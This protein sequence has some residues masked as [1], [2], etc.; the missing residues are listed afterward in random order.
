MRSLLEDAFND[1]FTSNFGREVELRFCGVVTSYGCT[2]ICDF[3]INIIFSP[4][5]IFLKWKC[6]RHQSCT[7]LTYTLIKFTPRLNR[8]MNQFSSLLWGFEAK[9]G[10]KNFVVRGDQTLDLALHIAVQATLQSCILPAWSAP[11]WSRCFVGSPWGSHHSLWLG[12][13]P[14]L[15]RVFPSKQHR[16]HC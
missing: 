14:I 2:N 13:K 16:P 3:F 5:Y 15:S 4:H 12:V 6:N 9:N 1:A 11:W 10:Q 8:H 7:S